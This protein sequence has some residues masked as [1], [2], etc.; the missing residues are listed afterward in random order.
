[1]KSPRSKYVSY[2]NSTSKDRLAAM[3]YNDMKNGKGKYET[4]ENEN[5]KV[6]VLVKVKN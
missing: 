6:K 3:Y 4:L 1:M 5:L 2:R